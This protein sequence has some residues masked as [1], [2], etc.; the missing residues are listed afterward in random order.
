MYRAALE[1][2]LYEQ[3]YKAKN[4]ADKIANLESEM[5][6]GTAPNWTKDFDTDMFTYL[7]DLGNGAIHPNDGDVKKQSILDNELLSRIQSVFSYLLQVVY[8][9]PQNKMEMEV[10]FRAKTQEFKKK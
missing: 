3:K 7:K 6:A 5:S 10:M 4:L 9:M 1:Q 2:L 8:E